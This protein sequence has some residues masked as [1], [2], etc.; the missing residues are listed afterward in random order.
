MSAACLQ[1]HHAERFANAPRREPYLFH[2]VLS[3]GR[4]LV[5]SI[6]RQLSAWAETAKQRRELAELSYRDLRDIGLSRH[7]V[8]A[9]LRKPFWR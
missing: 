9:E 7:D 1:T 6:S 8:E 5:F 2:R 4:T 3:T